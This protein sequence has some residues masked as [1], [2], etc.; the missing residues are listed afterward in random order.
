MI[1]FFIHSTNILFVCII[2]YILSN[3]S[4]ILMLIQH[5]YYYFAL[6]TN[7]LLLFREVI[8]LVNN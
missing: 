7:I 6:C 3:R 8:T 4:N 1:Y 5:K 2:L